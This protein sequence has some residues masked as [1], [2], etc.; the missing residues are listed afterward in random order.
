[1]RERGISW[2][3]DALLASVL[4]MLSIALLFSTTAHWAMAAEESKEHNE[5]TLQ[6]MNLADG[7]VKQ[8]DTRNPLFGAAHYN[9][10]KKRVESHWVERALLE[11][12]RDGLQHP[13]FVSKLSVLKDSEET[14]FLE[15]KSSKNCAGWN[16]F[17]MVWETKKRAILHVVVCSER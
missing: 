10:E 11:Q 1:M 4:F 6:S 2:S 7:M 16:R 13:F 14:V 12:A 15:K 8:F 17:V 3:L 9:S 5:L